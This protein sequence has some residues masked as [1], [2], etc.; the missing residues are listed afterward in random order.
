MTDSFGNISLPRRLHL[1]HCYMPSTRPP[2]Y[3]LFIDASRVG[4]GAYLMTYPKN[5]EQ[6]VRW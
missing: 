4:F 2:E 5:E 6:S 3:E 1:P